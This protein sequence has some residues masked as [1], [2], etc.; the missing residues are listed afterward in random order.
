MSVNRNIPSADALLF[1]FC[2]GNAKFPERLCEASLG[3]F[4][5]LATLCSITLFDFLRWQQ[6][7]CDSELVLYT[8]H[9]YRLIATAKDSFSIEKTGE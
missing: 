5:S 2:T 4:D 7:N 3:I 6:S 9:T 8:L 1:I